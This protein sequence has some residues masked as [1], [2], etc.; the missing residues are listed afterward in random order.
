LAPRS[1]ILWVGPKH[2]GKTTS[3][4]RLVQAAHASGFVVAGCLAP[5]VYANDLLTGFDIVDLRTSERTPLA[6]C[7]TRHGQD[8]SFQFTAEGLRLGRGAL[9]PTATEGADLIV[10]DEYGPLELKSQ[11]WRATTDRLMTS[12][13]A[14]LLLVVR[15][16]LV[17]K[18]LQL[19]GGIPTRKLIASQQGSIDEVLTVLGNNR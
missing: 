6:R 11:G 3:A 16:E 10:V 4:A 15:E 2:S 17:D 13:D 12:T 14:V 5:S 1:L 9:D 18:V 8:R 7:D 19:Y